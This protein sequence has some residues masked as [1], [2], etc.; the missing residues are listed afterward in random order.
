MHLMKQSQ[1]VRRVLVATVVI[2][3][4]VTFSCE[5]RSTDR[6]PLRRLAEATAR[7]PH[8]TIQARLDP[9]PLLPSC[10]L[11]NASARVTPALLA[12]SVETRRSAEKYPGDPRWLDASGVAWLLVGKPQEAITL[13]QKATNAAPDHAEYWNHLAAAW[14]EAARQG[15]DAQLLV[16]ALVAVDRA[17]RE[18]PLPSARFNRAAILAE[19]GLRPRAA[20][21]WKMVIADE[22]E[23]WA[24][25]ARC[26]MRELRPLRSPP[27][28]AA[29]ALA[30][31]ALRGDDQELARFVRGDP[32]DARAT[33]EVVRLDRW[34]R[35]VTAGHLREAD[36]QLQVAHAIGNALR[37]FSR[38]SLLSDA[39]N[40]IARAAPP[41]RAI[42]AEAHSRYLD[43]RLL[44]R[45]RK[46]GKSTAMF[47]QAETQF[48]SVGSPMELVARYYVAN[49]LY[50]EGGTDEALVIVRDLT[51]RTPLRYRALHAQL[52]WLRSSI[53]SR[54]GRLHEALAAARTS[55]ALFSELGERANATVMRGTQAGLHSLLGHR[56]ESWR[57]RREVF[58]ELGEAN[59][60]LPHALNTAART[61]ALAGRW[62]A[63]HSLLAI[64]LEADL[65][66]NRR[67]QSSTLVWHVLSA[68]RIGSVRIQHDVDE[69]R[70]VIGAIVDESLRM[71][72]QRELTFAEA[73]LLRDQPSRSVGVMSR[74][75]DE[76]R[77]KRDPFLLAEAFLARG[78][79]YRAL[80]RHQEAIGDFRDTLKWIAARRS[81]DAESFGEAY[82]ETARTARREL[83]DLLER[84]GRAEEA[85][86][87]FQRTQDID[88][89]VSEGVLL[90]APVVFADRLL[91]L[92]RSG[93]RVERAEVNVDGA[94]VRRTV[95]ILLRCIARDDAPCIIATSTTLGGWLLA[96]IGSKLAAARMLVVIPDEVVG[97]VPF[98]LLRERGGGPALVERLPSMLAPFALTR[99]MLQS[100]S[101][102]DSLVLVG[103]PA[104]DHATFPTLP[105][106]GGAAT[107]MKRISALY[108]NAEPLLAENATKAEVL[109]RLRSADVAHIGTH[110]VVAPADPQRSCLLLA[111][112]GSDS[113]A[114][115]VY[116]I[117]RIMLSSLRLVVLTG[118]RT[119]VPSTTAG[120]G[121]SIARAFLRSGTH[122]VVGTLW[123][124]TD[125]VAAN[126]G[127]A[128]HEE[129][130]RGAAVPEALQRVQLR[131]IQSADPRMRS[132]WA[133]AGLCLYV[134]DRFRNNGVQVLPTKRGD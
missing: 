1:V 86:T 50:E 69:A 132:P 32:Q 17:L 90:F 2:V 42:L 91:L 65:T 78:H 14:L 95:E 75:I 121:E 52:L 101:R 6:D 122:A 10:G 38:E 3:A 11:S 108:V 15:D 40:V 82:F 103:N 7:T 87:L 118:C 120:A 117:E 24:S 97:A 34:A 105:R 12:A 26:R 81:D 104:F 59:E 31:A 25:E 112:E 129:M 119:A 48:G 55:A 96:P 84:G 88:E 58:R 49:C 30:E 28:D 56:A 16:D 133:W 61:E 79:A 102:R 110:A 54:Q 131:M 128:L 68:D 92:T 107:E 44:Y 94:T 111:A 36:K 113:G 109:R 18:S 73:V 115:Y 89:G 23:P 9:L 37:E 70:S 126:I 47:R 43:A 85:F 74:F 29:A 134:G 46:I 100:G 13:L 41:A 99:L 116:E 33:A 66:G 67:L 62:E 8:L 64:A 83:I 98:S 125:D 106:L 63:A 53:E 77:A 51:I 5:R 45:A 72:A 80:G 21:A 19:M 27:R 114:L 20:V 93:T 60:A 57:I 127:I 71:D 39:V 76:S 130:L 123:D 35:A 22:E 4:T 124:S